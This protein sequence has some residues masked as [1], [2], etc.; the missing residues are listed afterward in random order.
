M[1]VRQTVDG[2]DGRGLGIN[3]Y[4]TTNGMTDCVDSSL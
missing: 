2:L 4:W 1:V 3:R